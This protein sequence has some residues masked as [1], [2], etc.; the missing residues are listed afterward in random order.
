MGVI[1]G[2][3]KRLG[4]I[5]Y[6]SRFTSSK[7][8]KMMIPAIFTSKLLVCLHVTGSIWCLTEYGKLE[9]PK[10]SCPNGI[11]QKLQSCQRMAAS[12]LFMGQHVNW[13]IRT[14]MLLGKANMMSV[15]Q[16]IAANTIRIA[17]NAIQFCKPK[18]I[19]D[20]LI[21]RTTRGRNRDR[22]TI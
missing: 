5:R 4:L 11:I 3:L 17:L 21:E 16:L 15:H 20:L 7:K 2:L 13:E 1:P 9:L 14:I 6:L 19:H 22:I 18:F 12:L 10:M 8:M